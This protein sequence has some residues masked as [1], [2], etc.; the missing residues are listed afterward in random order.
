MSRITNDEKIAK[1]IL[2]AINDYTID[3]LMVGYYIFSFAPVDLYC[4][5]EEIMEAVQ[6]AIEN[7]NERERKKIERANEH[8]LF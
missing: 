3:T 8:P 7:E 4:K 5:L 1:K 2:D 6:I